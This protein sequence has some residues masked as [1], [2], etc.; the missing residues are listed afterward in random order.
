MRCRFFGENLVLLFADGRLRTLRADG[1][2]IGERPGR[3]G[4]IDL[5]VAPSG[6]VYVSY[7][8]ELERIS[9]MPLRFPL[10]EGGVLAADPGGIWVAG[11]RHATRFRPVPGGLDLRRV[12]D[13]PAPARAACLGPDGALYLLLEPG[14]AL[15]REGG[16]AEPLGEPLLDLART[17]TALWACGSHGAV[18]LTRHVPPPE[19]DG[20]IFQL[21]SC[22]A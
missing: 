14:D 9:D 15:L 6:S 13:L 7:P 4:A 20:P 12:I 22:S 18:D 10:D 5:A 11:H 8:D 1:S 2:L 3:L 17:P 21:P 16:A 19:G